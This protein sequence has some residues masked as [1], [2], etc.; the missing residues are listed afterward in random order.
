MLTYKSD[1]YDGDITVSL[2]SGLSVTVPNDQFL[3]PFVSVERNGSR[4]YNESIK[5][6]LINPTN[7]PSTLG[8]YFFTS[9]YLM[10]NHDSNTFTMWQGNPSSSSNLVTVVSEKAA[11]SC[12]NVSGVIQPS[13]T[14][15]LTPSASAT[16]SQESSGPSNTISPGA[17][18]GATIGGVALLVSVGVA[19]SF[20]LRKRRQRQHHIRHEVPAGNPGPNGQVIETQR[21][22][23]E[24]TL[25]VLGTDMVSSH[26][27]DSTRPPSE[28][29]PHSS[30]VGIEDTRNTLSMQENSHIAHEMDGKVYTFQ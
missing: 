9:A 28:L 15:G 25:G 3:T 11:E 14:A 23:A 6:L 24:N 30:R 22:T 16:G 29:P 17:I 21:T 13:A 10:V 18:A 27:L 7:N 5:E 8:R 4:V 1:R 26:E 2:S 19:A 20:L 12:E